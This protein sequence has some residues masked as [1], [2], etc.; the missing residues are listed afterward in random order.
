MMNHLIVYAHPNPR[1]F[2]HAIMDTVVDLSD[3]KGHE[4]RV[5]DLYAMNFNPVLQGSDFEAFHKG[6]VPKDI[7]EEHEHIKWADTITFI[8]P[9]W[10]AA[11]P[12]MMKGYVDKVFSNGFAYEYVGGNPVGLLGDKT[13]I[14]LNTTGSPSD[15][16]EQ[17][18]MHDAIKLVS[19]T[20]KFQF[21]DMKV[22]THTFFGAVPKVDDD[23]RK[24][25]LQDV[26]RI[27]DMY[28]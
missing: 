23:T 16:Y 6:D 25:Y 14:I 4:T 15:L 12:A 21:C 28:L 5:R 27:M 8:Y 19:D 17:M 26:K 3:K 18:G 2:N 11:M 22:A 24:G 10:W 9:I 1:S 7:Q 13:V 20:G